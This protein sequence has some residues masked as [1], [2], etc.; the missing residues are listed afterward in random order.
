MAENPTDFKVRL[1]VIFCLRIPPAKLFILGRN[2]TISSSLIFFL[3]QSQPLNQGGLNHGWLSRSVKVELIVCSS[4]T[5]STSL[6]C[7]CCCLFQASGVLGRWKYIAR[8]R[9]GGALKWRQGVCAGLGCMAMLSRT[10]SGLSQQHLD[11][12]NF[13]CHVRHK[14]ASPSAL[15]PGSANRAFPA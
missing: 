15:S 13:V 3:S 5:L 11:E 1:M 6:L 7:L 14:C 12:M 8:L 9:C 2:C 4:S 10:T